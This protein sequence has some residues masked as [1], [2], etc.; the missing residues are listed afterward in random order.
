MSILEITNVSHGYGDKM[1]YKNADFSLYK[2]EHVGVVGKNGAGKST[3]LGICTGEIVPDS[4][5]TVWQNNVTFGCL[6]QHAELQRDI[7]ILTY[8]HGAFHSL[9]EQEKAMNLLYEKSGAGDDSALLKAA[10]LQSG[11]E[12][13]GFYEIDY[14]VEKAANGLGLTALGLDRPV[15]QLSGGQRAKVRLA[16]LLLEN[17]DVLLLDEP[18]NFL[19]R[20]HINWLGEQLSAS[21]KAFMVISHDEAFLERICDH[22]CDIENG[23][24]R[25]YTGTYSRFL[26]QKQHLR[27][28]YIRRYHSQQRE[29][30][31]TEAYIRKNIA[32]VNSK[33]AKGRR[34]QL[35]RLERLEAP[36]TAQS[37][38]EFRFRALPLHVQE[39]LKLKGLS[40][41]YYYPLLPGLSFTV[42]G[43]QKAVITGFNGIG[44]STLLKTLIGSLPPL[45]GS[46]RFAEGTVVGYYDQDLTFP[47][48][49]LTPLQTVAEAAP[50]LSAKEIRQQLFRCG[51]SKEHAQ[52]PVKSLSGGEQA[53]VKLCLLTLSPC[54][55]LILDEP[56]NHLDAAAKAALR[57]ALLE[58]T[59]TVLLVSHEEAFYDELA[60][61]VIAMDRL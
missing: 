10:A 3:L 17:P 35:E 25:K 54:N 23:E 2:G 22:I 28:D 53:K 51:I 60:H 41:G 49:T 20:S 38:P 46:F 45:A 21:E 61:R 59:G 26:T 1:I 47:D 5:R 30:E 56:T 55:L 14:Q 13:T 42:P 36:D 50:T 34:K 12:D 9:Y 48:G 6:D 4:G 7:T 15:S 44:K 29:I 11:L 19:D 58:F 18:T 32:G 43:G 27:E 40:V 52:Q 33:N 39:H 16:R 37:A 24:I 8:L 57:K 31:K